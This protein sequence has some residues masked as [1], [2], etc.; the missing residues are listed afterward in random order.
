[1]SS[2]YSNK[3]VVESGDVTRIVFLDERNSIV[4]GLP[5]SV[6]SA[7]EVVMTP[8]NAIELAEIILKLVKR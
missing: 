8:A 6:V 4:T 3:F 1:M 5:K 7:A 2:V